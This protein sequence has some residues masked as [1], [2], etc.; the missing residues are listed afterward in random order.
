[1]TSSPP[2]VIGEPT[3]SLVTVGVG[4]C[5]VGKS[6]RLVTYALGSCIAVAIVDPESDV[7]AL[8]HLKLPDSTAHQQ[9]ALSNQFYFAN[10]GIPAMV[11]A[12]TELGLQKKRARVCLIGGAQMIDGLQIGKQNHL[13]AKKALWKEGMM[14]NKEVVGGDKSRSVWLSSRG[15]LTVRVSGGEEITLFGQDSRDSKW[16][17]LIGGVR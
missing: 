13:A 15:S 6:I 2:P 16:N 10:L 7:G 8:L 4:D 5:K 17:G 3:E 9:L 1:M 11:K 14:V 12:A